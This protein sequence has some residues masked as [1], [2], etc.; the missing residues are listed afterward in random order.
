MEGCCVGR[1]RCRVEGVRDEALRGRRGRVE[2]S[3]GSSLSRSQ[4]SLR[5]TQTKD[6]SYSTNDFRILSAL[7]VR[8]V[9]P[10][11]DLDRVNEHR[12]SIGLAFSIMNEPLRALEE[13]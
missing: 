2:E 7:E 13:I 11:G 1:L 6:C 4:H 5:T 9:V 12:M 8:M 3:S 10:S